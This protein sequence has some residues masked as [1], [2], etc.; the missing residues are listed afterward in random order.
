MHVA[1]N[2]APT[3]I[4]ERRRK[5]FS[6]SI[7]VTINWRRL[8]LKDL[9]N[10]CNGELNV[11]IVYRVPISFNA[12]KCVCVEKLRQKISASVLCGDDAW[13]DGVMGRLGNWMIES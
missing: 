3:G 11:W 4:S 7:T 1:E 8:L 9:E 13:I 6:S 10:S 5:G 2:G 12:E